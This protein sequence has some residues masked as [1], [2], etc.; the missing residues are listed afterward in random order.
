MT[1]ERHLLASKRQEV[2]RQ[3]EQVQ[4]LSHRV[5]AELDEANRKMSVLIENENQ[6]ME[7]KHGILDEE[8]KVESQMRELERVKEALALEIVQIREERECSSNQMQIVKQEEI[9]TIGSESKLY[10]LREEVRSGETDLEVIRERIEYK[11]AQIAERT[12]MLDEKESM[13][14][15]ET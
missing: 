1:E 7:L 13:L 8:E 5:E 15:E 2:E 4:D 6:V 9:E 3:Q 12:V 10:H 14:S 11:K